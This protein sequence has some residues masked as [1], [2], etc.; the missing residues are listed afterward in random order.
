[1]QGQIRLPRQDRHSFGSS[2]EPEFQQPAGPPGAPAESRE[3]RA[4]FLESVRRELAPSG[5]IQ[6][7][8]ADLV[9]QA[10]WRLSRAVEH[11]TGLSEHAEE[12]FVRTLDSFERLRR[13]SGHEWG[14]SRTRRAMASDCEPGPACDVRRDPESTENEPP[15]LVEGLGCDFGG[16]TPSQLAQPHSAPAAPWSARLAFDAAISSRSPVIRGTKITA[17][18]IVS[19]VVDGLTWADIL[20]TY[21]ELSE[22]DIRAAL[23][24]TV[25]QEDGPD[26]A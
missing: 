24:Y 16:E 23:A 22:E 12:Q 13:R 17:R 21:P 2:F 18:R 25:E 5:L 3:E 15:C 10:A 1:M 19:L 26:L 11:E 7:L 9:A 20:R 8:L 4:A 14:V 6:G